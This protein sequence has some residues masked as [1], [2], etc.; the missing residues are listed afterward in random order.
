MSNDLDTALLTGTGTR[1]TIT[2]LINQA[3]VPTEQRTENP[4]LLSERVVVDVEVFASP[5]LPVGPY[6]LVDLPDGQY[7]VIG[8]PEDYTNGPFGQTP[9]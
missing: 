1:N 4:R 7:W 6:D 2:G 5:G 3:G 9:A 8:Q